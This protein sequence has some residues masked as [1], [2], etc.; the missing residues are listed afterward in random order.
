MYEKQF[1]L[2]EHPFRTT[3][4]P[5]FLWYSE[6]HLEAKDK[7]LY[8][9]TKSMGP[10]ALFAEIGTGKTTLAR[11]IVDELETDQTKHVVYVFSPKLTTTNSFLRFI[12]DEFGVKTD[13]NYGVSLRNF[14][15]YL[16][17]QH[18]KRMSP[19]LLIDEAQNMSKDM[20]L[21]IQH[22]FN[23]STSTE[24]L[25]QIALFS[26]PELKKRLRRLDS[27]R[28]RLTPAKLAP[29]TPEQTEE[30]LKFRW[31]VAGGKNFPFT[32]DA[33]EQI[34]HISHGIPRW[35]IKI[36]NESLLKTAIE[37]KIRVTKN[38]VIAAT[39]EISFD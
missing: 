5:R 23:F 27:L 18:Q 32:K 12:M 22:L 24:F 39:P 29:F 11:R 19:V 13:R 2:A 8:Y 31:T 15:H 21:L 37:K 17:Q 3:P 16:A 36:A 38:E 28:S 30:M 7:I 35:I 34:H 14:E 20:L 10:I 33:I 9:I 6:Q 25:I 1:G 26:Q 4:D